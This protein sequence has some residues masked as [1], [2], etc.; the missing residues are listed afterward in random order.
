MHDR[1]VLAGAR[2]F[3]EPRRGGGWR[4]FSP[5]CSVSHLIQHLNPSN[6]VWA[7]ALVSGKL[8]VPVPG[9]PKTDARTSTH[10]PCIFTKT[11]ESR[12]GCLV[13]GSPELQAWRHVVTLPAT[14]PY[15]QLAVM[16]KHHTHF[17]H[18]HT[19]D[20]K[21]KCFALSLKVIEQHFFIIIILPQGLMENYKYWK[22]SQFTFTVTIKYISLLS[23]FIYQYCFQMQSSRKYSS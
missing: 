21:N 2:L 18:T 10:A 14:T 11:V 9:Q 12:R 22:S 19:G 7:Q 13:N 8:L 17:R 15:Y 20:D 6:S 23:F 1:F 3:M 16:C 4:G 5:N